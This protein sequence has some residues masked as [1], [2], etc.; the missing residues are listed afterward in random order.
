MKTK[1]TILVSSFAVLLFVVAG[2][3]GGVHASS[4][5]GSYRQMQVY[6]E[7]LSRVQSE[8][9]EDPNIPKVTDGAL[10]GL[11][12]SLDANSSYLTPEAYKTLKAHKTDAKGDI[13][14]TV[15]KRFGYADV[16][17]VL[18]GSPADK[19]GIEDTD[20]F[21]SIEGQSTRD[22]SLP[23]IRDALEGPP[24]STVNVS[25]VR[26]RKA[27]PQ[28]MVIT[29]DVVTIPPVS[30]KMLEDGIGYIKVDALTKGKTQEIATKIKTLEKSGAKK[31]VLDLRNT[32]DGEE[33]EGIATANL[34]LNHGT[35][36]YLQGQKYPKQIFNADPEKAVVTNLPLVV[37]VNRGTAGA[38]EIVAAAVMENARGDVVGDKTFGSGS[39]QKVIDMPDGSALV[40][41]VAKYYSPSGK[42][43]QDTAVTPNILVADNNDD[44]IAPDEDENPPDDAQQEK[45]Q[46][47]NQPD[48]QLNRAIEVL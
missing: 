7:V 46:K 40:L 2:S 5:D 25:V 29:R 39:I 30:D 3:L 19:A 18:P 48:D 43:V 15:S 16:V 42:A 41:S 27:E 12:E 1:A 9:V 4:N 44:F 17:S 13:G 36:T 20:I 23:E 11:L 14:A 37:L 33:S 26:A 35:I 21:E 10:H 45:Q 8:Y 24:G 38:A 32:S 28:K 34:F 22:M 6:S 31:L 47:A